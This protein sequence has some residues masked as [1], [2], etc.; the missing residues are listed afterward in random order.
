MRYEGDM[1]GRNDAKYISRNCKF[2]LIR[3]L[4]SPR[5]QEQRKPK[6]RLLL[7]YIELYG[8]QISEIWTICF[9]I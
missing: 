3:L 4:P 2:I 7:E 8:S 5:Y 6:E 9:Q 1:R